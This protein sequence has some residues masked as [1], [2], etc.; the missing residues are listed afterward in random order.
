MHIY[1]IILSYQIGQVFCRQVE[2]VE[3]I[4]DDGAIMT[5]TLI[6]AVRSSRTGVSGDM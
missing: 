3:G 4:N 5:S 6:N 1:A 2:D